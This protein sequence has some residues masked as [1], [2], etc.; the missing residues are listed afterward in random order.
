MFSVQSS[1]DK[2]RETPMRPRLQPGARMRDRDRSVCALVRPRARGE[3]TQ[4]VMELARQTRSTHPHD[5]P[6]QRSFRKELH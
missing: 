4:G 1:F 2:I 6:D 3:S 5:I